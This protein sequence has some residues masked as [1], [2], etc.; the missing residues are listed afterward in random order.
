MGDW[1]V[2]EG[3][4]EYVE[5]VMSMENIWCLQGMESSLQHWAG[6]CQAGVSGVGR[7][8]KGE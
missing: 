5:N 1:Q 2:K 3:R 6:R 8:L 7:V 4:Q